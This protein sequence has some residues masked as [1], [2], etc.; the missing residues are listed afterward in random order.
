VGG[1]VSR[2]ICK[3]LVP[4]LF[5]NAFDLRNGCAFAKRFPIRQGSDGACHVSEYVD[6][7]EEFHK[8]LDPT[9]ISTINM[10]A[11]MTIQSSKANLCMTFFSFFVCVSQL[12]LMTVTSNL[13]PVSV[14]PHSPIRG[15]GCVCRL[16]L[17]E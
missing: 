13:C 4:T 8:N 12:A 6:D 5:L 9:T 14:F 2:P 10:Q 1:D 3:G 16:Q 15:A 11:M 17:G 7:Y